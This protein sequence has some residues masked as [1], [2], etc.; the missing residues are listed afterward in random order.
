MW[1]TKLAI[2]LVIIAF[3]ELFILSGLCK[4]WEIGTQNTVAAAAALLTAF[5]DIIAAIFLVAFRMDEK[6]KSGYKAFMAIGVLIAVVL[7]VVTIITLVQ[8]RL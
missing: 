2:F 1:K 6:G 5:A 3:A 4:M 8:W 7:C